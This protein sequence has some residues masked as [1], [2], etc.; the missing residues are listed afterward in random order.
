MN[1]KILEEI[2]LTKGETRVYLTLLKIGETTTG[3]IIENAQISSGKIYEILDK[4]IKKGLVSYIVKEK[5][6]YFSAASPERIL[7]YLHEKEMDIHQKEEMFLKELPGLLNLN[8]KKEHETK[9]FKGI[10]GIQTAI[11]ESLEK[12]NKGQE[13]LAMGIRST[14]N[15]KFNFLWE[16]WHKERIHKKLICKAIFSDK[17][18]DYYKNF[19]KMK[20]TRIKVTEGVTPS[21]IDIMGNRVLIFTYENEPSCLVIENEEIAKSFTTFFNTMWK[22]GKS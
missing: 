8:Q 20:M 9:L 12:M 18:T 13:V 4:L 21:A 11:F 6:K 3:K 2:G 17:N 15:E 5:T 16:R 10:K 7:D 22:T 14:K 19:K 1:E